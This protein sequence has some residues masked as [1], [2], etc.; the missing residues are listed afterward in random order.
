MEDESR[1]RRPEEER[2]DEVPASPPR[3]PASPLVTEGL[4][5]VRDS[6]C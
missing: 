4:E 2:N 3:D 6:H 5:Q 1:K